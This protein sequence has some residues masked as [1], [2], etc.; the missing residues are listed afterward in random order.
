MMKFV[1]LLCFADVHSPRYLSLF[2]AS[3]ARADT[4]QVS[5]V[6]MAGDIVE[7]GRVEAMRHIMTVLRKHVRDAPLYAVFGNE[8][9]FDKEREFVEAYPEITW[10]NDSVA[11]LRVEGATIC[12]VGSRGVLARPTHWQ[13]RHI[14][15][16]HSLYRSRIRRIR[17]LLQKCRSSCSKVILLTHYA[18]SLATIRG[19]PPSIHSYLGYPIVEGLP[20]GA[21]PDIAIHGHAHNSKVLRAVVNGVEVHNVALPARKSV[22]LINVSLEP[23]P[24]RRS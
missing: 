5:A 19:E 6:L 10:L 17:E 2:V 14:P 22:T 18:S 24:Q 8:E 15:N 12:I 11:E 3:M 13:S 20:P 9:Y 1:K 7:R 4:S 23:G 16:I 21:R